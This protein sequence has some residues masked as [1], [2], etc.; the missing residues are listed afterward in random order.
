MPIRPELRHL[1]RGPEWEAQRAAA[2]ERAGGKCATCRRAHPRLNGAHRN[3]DPRDRSSVVAWCPT[4]HA[5]HDA[6]HRL[7]VM[8]RSHAR[9]HGQLWLLPE[10]EYAPDPEWMIPRAV[11]R[12][13]QLGLFA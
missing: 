13:A 12:E 6:P 8:R 9:R 4:C 11:L 5:R 10:L 2:I 3:H 7:A 1:Y